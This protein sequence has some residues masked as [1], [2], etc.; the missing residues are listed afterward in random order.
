[1]VLTC[2]VIFK[3]RVESGC[4]MGFV[5]R[6]DLAKMRRCRAALVEMGKR[7]EDGEEDER[8]DLET[9]NYDRKQSATHGVLLSSALLPKST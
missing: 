6:A 5:A 9:G 1:M 3:V 7:S 4:G 2:V 8:G